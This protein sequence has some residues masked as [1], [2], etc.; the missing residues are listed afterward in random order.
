M[1]INQKILSIPPYISTTWKNVSS[2][3][4]ESR[5]ST[6]VL[7][8]LLATG[9]RIE[10]PGMD[11]GII[12]A[13]F[14]AH[15]SFVEMES[16]PRASKSD[17]SK[18]PFL[19]F[20]LPV[21]SDLLEAFDS[22]GPLLQHNAERSQDPDLPK[23]L[24]QKVASLAKT[25]GLKD[26]DL[27]PESEPHCNCMHCQIAKALKQG[28][29]DSVEEVHEEIVTEEDLKFRSWDIS[30]TGDKLYSVSNPLDIQEQYS[31]YLGEPVGCTCG[32]PHCEHIRAVL[33]S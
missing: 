27:I 30:K 25:L 32:S 33:N 21:K 19:S 23:G 16:A 26:A 4:V 7:V 22:L 1:R 20:G 31:V 13:I 29:E 11:P 14:A 10:I 2:L 12:K 8:I 18:N 5:H 28:I 15:A 3:H 6:L 24:L 9:T 17:V